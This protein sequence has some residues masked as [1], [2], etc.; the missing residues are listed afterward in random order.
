METLLD[1]N[2]VYIVIRKVC[3]MVDLIISLYKVSLLS[4]EVSSTILHTFHG[5]SVPRHS[6][7]VQSV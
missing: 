4:P 5:V 3:Q 1:T 6:A 7:S 2:T